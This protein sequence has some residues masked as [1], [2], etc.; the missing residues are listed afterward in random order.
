MTRWKPRSALVGTLLANRYRIVGPV[1]QG[2]T[3][4]VFRADDIQQGKQVAV[5]V[6]VPTLVQQPG[7]IPRIR[8]RIER[9]TAVEQREPGALINLVDIFD[10]GMT[11]EGELFVVTDFIDGDHLS[12]MLSRGGRLPWSRARSLLVRLCQ[13]LHGLHGHGIVLGALEA[14][15]CYAVRGKNKHEAIK[16]VSSA[17]YE[18]LASTIG[19]HAGHGATMLA[20]YVAPEQACG[21]PIDPRADIYSFGVIAFELLTGSVPFTDANPMRLVSMHIQQPPRPPRAAA[22]DAGIPA[23]VEAALLRCLAKTPGERFDSMDLLASVL[24]AI[25]EALPTGA[26]PSVTASVA[27]SEIPTAPADLHSPGAAAATLAITN[28]TSPPA[29]DSTRPVD[30]PGSDVAALGSLGSLGSLGTLAEVAAQTRQPG[31]GAAAATLAISNATS[32]PAE[33]ATR[34]VDAPAPVVNEAHPVA[35]SH[36]PPIEALPTSSPGAPGAAAATLAI[37]NR[38]SPPAEDAERP[39]DAPA[40]DAPA[41]DAPKPGAHMP[42]AGIPRTQV[43]YP[44]GSLS[45][46]AIRGAPAGALGPLRLPPRPT[47]GGRP[48]TIPP[49]GFAP[50]PSPGAAA[51]ATPISI[52]PGGVPITLPRPPSLGVPAPRPEPTPAPGPLQPSAALP[53]GSV[54]APEASR[55]AGDTARVAST[56]SLSASLQDVTAPADKLAAADTLTRPTADTPVAAKPRD[57]ETRASSS[58]SRRPV[59]RL[60]EQAASSGTYARSVLADAVESARP[61][62]VSALPRATG[63]EPKPEARA[64]PQDTREP[65]VSER[66]L[67]GAALASVSTAAVPA[68]LSQVS[69]TTDSLVAQVPRNKRGFLYAVV[70]LAAAAGIAALVFTSPSFTGETTGPT[71]QQAT[72]RTPPAAGKLAQA[73]TQPADPATPDRSAGLVADPPEPTAPEP[74]EDPE[75]PPNPTAPDPAL[76]DPDPEPTPGKK[77]KDKPGKKKRVRE[78]VEPEEPEKDV[79]DQLREHMAKKKAQE[80]EYAANLARSN[81]PTPA[82]APTPAPPPKEGQTDAEKAKET[83]ERAKQA[84]GSGNPQ[85]GYTLA[86]QSYGLARSQEALEIMGTC[87]CRLKNE[88]NARAAHVALSGSPRRASVIEACTKTGITL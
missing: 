58:G 13:I 39:V 86:K 19:P 27:A 23:E 85:L 29:E 84:A 14:R 20:R 11:L 69:G 45:A 51:T 6:L 57:D 42:S 59:I 74:D 87:A 33:D 3:G 64:Q 32:P 56:L 68:S 8:A 73:T 28:R 15:H 81:N 52:S 21:E 4:A 53:A 75:V 71:P 82:P 88:A 80:A 10:V 35:S 49:G 2:S 37:T 60:T 48:A 67:R 77:T 41:S 30:A 26:H 5:R 34:P 36:T 76:V 16:V 12:T 54:P 72:S 7:L 78:P 44:P 31:P 79:F 17:I 55:I 61:G 18:Q 47:L 83:L 25:P 66:A 1:G 22:P 9:N 70:G 50:P 62:P 40:P 46:D 24:L 63:A 65:V 43:T 38:T